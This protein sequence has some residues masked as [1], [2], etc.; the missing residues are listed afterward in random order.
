MEQAEDEIMH[1]KPIS[2]K[3]GMFADGLAVKIVIEGIM[4][5]SLALTSFVIGYKFFDIPNGNTTP[6][7][8][9]T[10]S[11][12]VLSLSQLFHSFNM[13]SEHSLAEIG[14]FS[15]SK[16][17]ISFIICFFLQ[18]AVVSIPALSKLF[19]VVPLDKRQWA[20]VLLLSIV[21]I[22]V[23]ELQKK[24]NHSKNSKK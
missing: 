7:I 12:S 19:Q 14:M 24:F 23:V 5:G 8:G 11:F 2:P 1:R 15:N 13:R 21:P 10:M 3:K 22:L 6:W 4:I 16:L 17:T 9:R 18:V 20:T